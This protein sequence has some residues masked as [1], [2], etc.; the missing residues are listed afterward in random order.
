MKVRLDIVKIAL[1]RALAIGEVPHALC[2]SCEVCDGVRHARATGHYTT[3][4]NQKEVD[5]VVRR[6][7]AAKAIREELARRET[8]EMKDVV[9]CSQ[10]GCIRAAKS[11]G[12]CSQHYQEVRRALI[13]K[14]VGQ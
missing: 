7:Q 9:T 5:A 2:L 11:K 3:R 4:L 12:L 14:V 6:A 8:G 13:A 10:E 1:D